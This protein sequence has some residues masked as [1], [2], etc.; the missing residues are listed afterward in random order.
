MFLQSALDALLFLIIRSNILWFL[1]DIL[2]HATTADHL[3]RVISEFF[4][5]CVK[6]TF[7]LQP[8]KCTLFATTIRWCVREI[9]SEGISFAPRRIDGI[10]KMASL[11]T[12]AGFTLFVCAIQWICA[13]ISTFSSIIRPLVDVLENVY[14][15]AGKR[16]LLAA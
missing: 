8:R 1:D 6:E 14:T 15:L 3:L 13:G 11:E 16:T 7:Q 9:S 4:P 10:R 12:E 5:F 2:I